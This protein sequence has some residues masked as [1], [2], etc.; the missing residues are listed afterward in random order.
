M[1]L[2]QKGGAWNKC[3]SGWSD[4]AGAH[5]FDPN[6]GHQPLQREEEANCKSLIRKN[7]AQMREVLEEYKEDKVIKS[8]RV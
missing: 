3:R 6:G 1:V 7:M 8:T 5:G 2:A 4:L